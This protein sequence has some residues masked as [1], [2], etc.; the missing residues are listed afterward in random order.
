M[1]LYQLSF[2]LVLLLTFTCSAQVLPNQVLSSDVQ[3]R[4]ERE[5]RVKYE[6]PDSVKLT[7]SEPRASEFPNYD[8]LSITV[9][10]SGKK[11]Y[12]FLLSKDQ[13]TLIRLTKLDLSRDPYAENMR[14]I[15]IKGRPVR[16]NPNAKVVVVSYDDFECP[17]CSRA[18]NTL[19]PELLKEYGDKIAFV[20]KDFPLSDMHPW[21]IHAAVDANCLAAQSNDAYWDFADYI[22]K[23]QGQV[24]SQ[25]GRTNQFAELDR[26]T[27]TEGTKFNV[28]STKLQ[29]CVKE[30]KQDAVRA[31]MKEGES[32]G[33][34]GTPTIYVN[35]E[36]LDGARSADEF[37][38]VFDKA[39]QQVGV[40]PPAHPTAQPDTSAKS[41]APAANAN[42]TH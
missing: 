13:K 39:L 4:I 36:M 30:Q 25:S 15:D 11:T 5:I 26:I 6:L 3:Q 22:H 18:H 16:G 32:L 29:A 2:P 14:K 9:G 42:V 1:K 28:D 40:A 27:E 24:N 37:R 31:S 23:N 7:I 12:E 8:A 35:G 41:V 17:F 19:F 21:A 10:D 33:I 38:A 34:D 20:Y